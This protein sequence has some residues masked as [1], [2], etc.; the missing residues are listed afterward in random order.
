MNRCWIPL[1][2]LLIVSA[3][4]EDSPAPPPRQLLTFPT[5]IDR[6]CRNGQAR[7]FDECSDQSKLFGVALAHAKIA[8]KVLL[9][10]YGA[11]WCI[12]CHVF[13]AHITGEHGRFRYTYGSPEEPEERYTHS[14]V[15]GVG[16]D[17]A[18]AEALRDFVAANFVMVYIDAQYAPNGFAV[19]EN[20]GAAEH[21]TGGVPYVFTVD[22][23]GRYAARFHHDGAENRRDTDDDWYRGYHRAKLQQ[24]LSVMRDAARRAT[25]PERSNKTQ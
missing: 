14:F 21:F 16:D 25:P 9:V 19:L 3:C 15:E 17:L 22:P 20:S 4:A 11:E 1:A 23:H 13:K 5:S 2:S 18:Q 12:W 10:E 7:M 24:Q 8:D 6:Q